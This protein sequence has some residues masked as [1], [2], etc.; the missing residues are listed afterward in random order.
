[1]PETKTRGRRRRSRILLGLI[2]LAGFGMRFAYLVHVTAKPGYEWV[3][4]DHYKEKG[5]L[6]AG[7]GEAW[8][9]TFDAVRHSA[10]DHRY[11]VLPP[12]YPSF[13]SLFALFPGYPFNAQVGQVLLSSLIIVLMFHLGRQIHSERAGLAA[14]AV[15]AAWLP[16]IIAVWSTMQEA[17]YIPLVVLSFVLFLRGVGKESRFWGFFLAGTAFGLTALTRSMPVYF[18]PIAAVFLFA[19]RGRKSGLQIAGLALGFALATVPYS[20]ALSQHLGEPTFIE[21]H[22]SIMV[23]AHYGGHRL[24]RPPTLV[25]TAVLIARAVASSP[26]EVLSDWWQTGRSVFHVNGGRLL[27]IYLGAE[28]KVGALLWKLATHAAADF[29]FVLCLLLSPFGFVLCRRR[30]LALFLVLWIL[31]NAALTAL[32]GFG[33]AR[34]RAPF[35]P[36]LILLAAVVLA[37]GYRR[38]TGAALGASLLCSTALAGIVVPQLPESLRARADYGV[39]W[40]LESPPKRSAMT[41]EAGFNVLAVNGAIE[42]AVRPRNPAGRT[43]VEVALEGKP[44]ERVVVERQQH[45]FRLPWFT[46]EL[47]HVE[48]RATDVD[49]GR[50]VRLLVIVPA[51]ELPV[52]EAREGHAHG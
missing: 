29:L 51:R 33:G 17:L 31:L 3:D 50:P 46:L 7:D 21:N 1:M 15:F 4:P 43:S 5:A 14:A 44:A 16:N 27:Q 39:S 45:D 11:Y 42:F 19:R 26:N 49:T 6:L 9:W 47:V 40:S 20:L 23:V 25:E 36:H 34:L 18:M 48:L 10:A 52:D 22:G 12:L 2:L 30:P 41:G 35:E 13:L 8:R 37:G 38:V 28:G 24:Q 32:S